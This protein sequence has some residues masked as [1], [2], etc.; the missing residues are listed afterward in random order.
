MIIG[1]GKR[2][3]LFVFLTFLL[4]IGN[5]KSKAQNYHPPTIDWDTNYYVS[6]VNEL[7]ARIYTSTKYASLRYLNPSIGKNLFYTPNNNIILGVGA[8]YS[9][10]TLNIGLNFPFVNSG[11]TTRYGLSD[12]WDLQTHVY[13]K[14]I[15]LDLYAQ[16]YGGYYLRNSVN[17]L[18]NW[19]RADTFY[20]RPDIVTYN[21]G[22]NAQYIFN[23][24]K[25][26]YRA[27]YIQNEWQKKSAGSWVVGANMFYITNTGDSLIIPSNIDPPDMFDG[28]NFKRKDALNIGISGGYYYTLVMAEHLFF[29]VGFAGGPS[30]GYSWLNIN[31]SLPMQYSGVDLN[32]NGV[33]RASLGYNSERL[34]VGTFF[35]NQFVVNQLP[36]ENIWTNLSTGN[37]RI[38]LVYRFKLKKPM[39]L[40]NVRYWDFLYKNDKEKKKK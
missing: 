19:P 5:Q 30:I 35:L 2:Y 16:I 3:L 31:E 10:F 8:T 14:K 1:S 17:V 6:Y 25:F 32:F 37:F 40:V 18:E 21:L 9:V 39:K 27:I 34:W 4:L 36:V 22:W 29:S 26:S 13:T 23:Y 15:T 20:K 33:F 24:K 7:S 38:I 12:Y 28:T 11:D